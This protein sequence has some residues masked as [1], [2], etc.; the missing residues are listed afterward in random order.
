MGNPLEWLA[1]G[2]GVIGAITVSLNLGA[3][4]TGYGFVVFL[5]SSLAWVVIGWRDNEVP[6][7]TLNAVLTA[8][9]LFGIYRWLLAPRGLARRGASA[10]R[11]APQGS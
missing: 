8:V 1:M 11:T 3:R 6:L 5:V 9:N 7:M 4:I 2:T 10:S